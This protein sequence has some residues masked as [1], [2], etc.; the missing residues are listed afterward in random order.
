MAKKNILKIKAVIIA[1][2]ISVPVWYYI[3]SNSE[4]Q[5]EVIYY[6]DG[7][8]ESWTN[9]NRYSYFHV[10]EYG[11]D[12]EGGGTDVTGVDYLFV[13][14]ANKVQFYGITFIW[15][16]PLILLSIAFYYLLIKFGYDQNDNEFLKIQEGD[17]SFSKA[18]EKEHY[19][20]TYDR[21]Q[22]YYAEHPQTG[23]K[24]PKH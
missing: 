8:I 23:R 6:N 17:I 5:T 14:H 10:L 18:V 7:E 24:K 11:P 3:A 22:E 2:A 19:K 4:I 20:E 9:S 16:I 15:L 12:W 21:Q 13:L 1:L